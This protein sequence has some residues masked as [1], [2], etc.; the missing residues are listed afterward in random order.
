METKRKE[1]A[2]KKNVDHYMKLKGIEGYTHLLRNIANELG[3]KGQ[4]TYDFAKKEK[5]NFS[6]MLNEDRPLKYDFIVPLEKILGVSLA[7]LLDEDAY[8]L[9]VEK[10]NVPYDKGYKYYAYLDNP[11]LY[12]KEFSLLWPK[13]DGTML[14]DFDEFGK[15]FLD[16]VVEYGSVNGVRYLHDTY[17]MKLKWWHNHFDIK[18][19]NGIQCLQSEHG[20]ELARLVASMNDVELFNDI[21]DSYNMFFSNGHYGSDSCIYCDGEFLEIILDNED[22]FNSLFDERDYEYDCDYEIRP[23]I[24]PI[25]NNCLRY[26]LTHLDKY[27]SKAVKILDFGIQYNKKILGE[28]GFEYSYTCNELGGI[29]SRQDDTYYGIIIFV[30]VKVEDDKEIEILI[31]QLPKFQGKLSLNY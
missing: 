24:N 16:Y 14:K 30:D 23:M 13:K 11:D 2:L 10:E 28:I 9:P 3:I 1:T 29:K 19:V 31:H 5:S 7:R 21:Y 12:D 22:I 20:I 18:S 25:I 8:K 6:K 17:G 26:A 4:A 15:T 27:R